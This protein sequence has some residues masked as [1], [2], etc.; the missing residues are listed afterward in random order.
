MRYTTVNN[1]SFQTK[2]GQSFEIKDMREYPDYV[3]L[4]ELKINSN[5]NIDEIASRE[6]I[7]GDDGEYLSFKIVDF[8]K[9]NLFEEK[10]NLNN[11]TFIKIPL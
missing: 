1:I 11:I 8:N 4:G 3:L 9:V 10:F 6:E 7:Y 2:S 5:D